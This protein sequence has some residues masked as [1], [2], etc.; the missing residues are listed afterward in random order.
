[1][2]KGTFRRPIDSLSEGNVVGAEGGVLGEGHIAKLQVVIGKVINNDLEGLEDDHQT[3]DGGLEVLADTL[4][5]SVHLHVGDGLGD[6]DFVDEV[7]DSTGGDTT[8]TQG[9]EGVQARI[10]PVTDMTLLNELDDLTLGENGSGD[11]ETAVFALHGTVDI[12]LVV[13]PFIRNTGELELSCAERV[14]DTLNTIAQAV[15]E[16]VSRETLEPLGVV[17]LLVALGNAP[18]EQIPHL[19]VGVL[20]ILLHAQ[21]SL[22]GLVLAVAHSA[23]LSQRFLN[24]AC[25]VATSI[26]LTTTLTIL[27]LTTLSLDLSLGAMA[28]VGAIALDK[29]LSELVETLKVVTGIGLPHGLEAEPGHNVA[30]SSVVSL[31]LTGGVCVVET[32]DTLASVVAREAK[33]HS[34]GLAVS[35]VKET[36]GLGRET[37]ANLG[38]GLGDRSLLVHVGQEASLEQGFGVAGCG[39]LLSRLRGLGLLLL[40]RLGVQLGLLFLELLLPLSLFFLQLLLG[41]TGRGSGVSVSSRSSLLSGHLGALWQVNRRCRI[42]S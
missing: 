23:E 17:V 25:A 5:E 11:V 22:S 28:D 20:E 12:E 33:V 35:D 40:G 15:G 42:H 36:V 18:C 32:E 4:V 6:S 9:D 41:R 39:G 14:S 8:A 21:S 19:R 26:A 27:T 13:K 16:I 38:M 2:G 7:Q 34:N 29:L 24:G 31:L 37:G 3:G 1:M 30:N 10:V